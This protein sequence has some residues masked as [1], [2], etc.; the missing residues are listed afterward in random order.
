MSIRAVVLG[1]LAL[2]VGLSAFAA[3]HRLIVVEDAGGVPALPYYRAINLLPSP[4]D[5]AYIRPSVLPPL[6]ARRYSEADFLPVHSARL[7]PGRIVRRVIAAPGLQ[8]LCLIG[9]D[10]LSRSWLKAHLATLQQL[11]AVG[12]IV[13][14]RSYAATQALRA[15]APGLVLV[16]ASGDDIA[17]RLALHHYPVLIT[18]TGIEQ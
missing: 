14:V 10:P 1:C 9:D 4:R 13:E 12:L 18:T 6:Q 8:P 15:L 2:S 7:T 16:P 11:H 3:G 5:S 17:R